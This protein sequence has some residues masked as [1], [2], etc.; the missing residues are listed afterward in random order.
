[1]KN[2]TLFDRLI[3]VAALTAL[4]TVA[5]SASAGEP[6]VSESRYIWPADYM[7]DPAAHLFDGKIWVYTS[8][9]WDSPVK[10]ADDG[11][12][13]DMKDYHV[14]SIEGDPMTGEVTDHGAILS[15]EDVPWVAR[16]MWATD[17]AE[18]DGRYYL[19]FSAKDYNGLFRIGVAVADNPAGPFKANPDPI[20]GTYSIDPAVLNDNGEYYLVFGGLLG[21]QNHRYDR[22]N[23]LLE[24]VARPVKGD[25]A[26]PPRIARLSADMTA[27]AE[28]PRPIIITDSLG[29]ELTEDNP[30]RFFE[31]PW[32]HRYGDK[33][34][35]TYSTGGT[36]YICYAVADSPYGP[37]VCK[38]EILTP[39]VGWT[40]HQSIVEKDG[41]W[42]L[43]YHDSTPSGG[44]SSLRSTKVTPLTH[45][46]DGSIVKID[47]GKKK[48]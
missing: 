43:F 47:G 14:F 17:V 45:R 7:A 33:Y 21:G 34:Y 29:N 19:Y 18:K 36:H 35:L 25:I 9:D 27:L 41:R 44:V 24:S 28:Q 23:I 16:Q 2:S 8:H 30:H 46:P 4:F 3:R 20:R 40:T 10:N 37:Y 12:H 32:I 1:M 42:Y 31:A 15:I 11:A 5:S 39:V 48:K 13:Y 6:V 26:I 38:G 22:D